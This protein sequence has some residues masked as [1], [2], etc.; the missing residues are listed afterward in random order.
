MGTTQ[1]FLD[2]DALVPTYQRDL[3]LALADPQA[4]FYEPHWSTPTL[5]RLRELLL[6]SSAMTA[7]QFD[8]ELSVILDRDWP[9]A[10]VEADLGE[11]QYLLVANN[12][13]ETL[14]AAIAAR[15][16]QLVTA[17]PDNFPDNALPLG[18]KALSPD[19]FLQRFYFSRRKG[20]FLQVFA[21]HMASYVDPPIPCAIYLR[22]L[23]AEGL[24]GIA[25]DLSVAPGGCQE[26]DGLAD[27][28]RRRGPP[29]EGD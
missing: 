18:I 21:K 3:L 28:Y 13:R 11:L 2:A 1:A 8:D 25:Y 10:R 23:H 19:E 9:S 24:A 4:A 5:V 20:D 16:D 14:G 26:L 7:S 22:L 12:V 6:A 17:A 29:P 15:A 27:E